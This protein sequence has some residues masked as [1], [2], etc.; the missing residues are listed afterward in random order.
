MSIRC[1]FP[2]VRGDD[3]QHVTSPDLGNLPNELLIKIFNHLP[4]RDKIMIRHVSRRF[5]DVSEIPVLWKEFIWTNY[6]PRHVYTVSNTLKEIGAHVRKIFFPAH[7]KPTKILE[8]VHLCTSL[9]HLS[10][11]RDTQ[12]TLDGL[13]QIVQT[14]K[15]LQQLDLFTTP[16]FILRPNSIEHIESSEYIRKL[17]AVIAANVGELKLR[18]K[19][20]PD[21]CPFIDDSQYVLTSIE[22]WA[23][24]GNP[25]P[26]VINILT[27]NNVTVSNHVFSIWLKF[28]HLKLPSFEIG[29]YDNKKVP[30]DLY[31]A[32]PLRQFKFGPAT[33]ST[34]I[35]LSNH[36]I[37]GLKDDIFY[38]CE[39]N[40]YDSVSHAVTPTFSFKWTLYQTSLD[41]E[42]HFNCISHLDSV[43]YFDIS[44]E[45]VHSN[46]L[47][48][49]AVV[50]PNLQR[51]NLRENVNCLKDLQGFRAIVHTCHNLQGIN[52][53]G[54]SVLWVESHL[55]L[56]EL[57]SSVKKLTLLAIDLCMLK[58][59]DSDDA[60]KQK[61]INMF[62][63]CQSLKALEICRDYIKGC[64]ECTNTTDFLFS[65]FPSLVHCR[66]DCF[67]YSAFPYAIANCH[68]LKYLYEKD[69]RALKENLFPLSSNCQL[70]QLCIYSLSINLTDDLVETLSAHGELECVV[71][72]VKSI[73]INGITTLINNSPN[74]HVLH[75][76][77]IEP[78]FNEAYNTFHC[79]KAYTYTDRVKEM[80]SYHKLFAMSSFS[81]RVIANKILRGMLDDDLLDTDLNSLWP[82][83]QPSKFH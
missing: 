70:Q 32:V 56:W 21:R 16:N 2:R 72:C 83:L 42:M 82:P 61:L 77:M 64:E 36:G 11:H 76:S 4:T 1:C 62:K 13:Q 68:K 29:L 73:T 65:Y 79:N 19:Y 8:M 69:A 31:S 81:V 40:H 67:R 6:E 54:I 59:C 50:C 80:M 26:P 3:T 9:T 47:E 10:L 18:I 15:H 38:L 34:F 55:L 41:E 39:Y 45:N 58:S 20:Y 53:T 27:E 25:L 35:R 33:L 28:L 63:C 66:M 57:L 71:I 78:L 52:L 12:L 51:L 60:N 22:K 74:L 17:L 44:H 37:V 46:H 49:L 5:R 75:I 24:Q 14:K 30:M 7:V 43:T 48:Q 23:E